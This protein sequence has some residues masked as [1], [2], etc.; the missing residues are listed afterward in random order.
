MQGYLLQG[1]E[2]LSVD[3]AEL[4]A[5]SLLYRLSP[6]SPNSL[7]PF[8]PRFRLK[9]RRLGKQL[10]RH[11]LDLLAKSMTGKLGQTYEHYGLAGFER[12]RHRAMKL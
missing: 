9:R 10:S 4:E 11:L 5:I 7:S 1:A 6:V 12:N 8:R 3:S 2:I